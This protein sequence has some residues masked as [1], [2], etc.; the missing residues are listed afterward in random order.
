VDIS[1]QQ[2]IVDPSGIA[3]DFELSFSRTLEHDHPV[4]GKIDE[5]IQ[6]DQPA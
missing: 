5:Q 4:T 6:P 1:L 3:D 2:R